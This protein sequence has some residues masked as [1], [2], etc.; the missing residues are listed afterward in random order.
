MQEVN[1]SG[2]A[3]SKESALQYL[4]NS[5]EFFFNT[6]LTSVQSTTDSVLLHFLTDTAHQNNYCL[7]YRT[8]PFNFFT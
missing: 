3:E 4:K 8:L 2:P 5:Q 6:K 1:R 7:L